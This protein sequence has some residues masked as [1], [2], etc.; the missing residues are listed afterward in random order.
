M[1][2]QKVGGVDLA[3]GFQASYQSSD[4]SRV[5]WIHPRSVSPAS[6]LAVSALA[7]FTV[8]RAFVKRMD[9]QKFDT[10]LKGKQRTKYQ[11]IDCREKLELCTA[12]IPG[13]DIIHLPLSACE[14][15]SQKVIA[16]ELLDRTKPTLVLCQYGNRARELARFL[17]KLHVLW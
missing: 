1:M 12:S 8:G 13:D 6:M 10:I 7:N 15:W 2:K 3:A 5:S 16:G 17:S 11:I 14:T 4:L 9:L